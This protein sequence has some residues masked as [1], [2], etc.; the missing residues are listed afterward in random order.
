[1]KQQE[2]QK[3]AQ[4]L[5]RRQAEQEQAA[6]GTRREPQPREAPAPRRRAACTV[7]VNNLH[8]AEA[9]ETDVWPEGNLSSTF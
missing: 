2:I 3:Q 4:R 5:L 1:M 9:I 6:G 8:S 7:R